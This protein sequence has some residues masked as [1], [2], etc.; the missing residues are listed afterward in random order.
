MKDKTLVEEKMQKLIEMTARFCDEHLDE[1][2]KQLCE[3]LIRKM[4]R[5]RNVPFLSGRI[6]IWAAAIVYAIGSI[7]FLF[8]RNFEPYVSGDDICNYFGTS[9]STTS[10]KAKLIRDMFKLEHWD[11]E[12]STSQMIQ[13]DPFRDLVMVNGF[14]VSIKS[15]PPELQELIRQGESHKKQK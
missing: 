7:N 11:R 5:K 2:Y 4:S 13:N 6:E 8:D 14:I 15:L 9:K 3:K 1:E 10:Q 12:F